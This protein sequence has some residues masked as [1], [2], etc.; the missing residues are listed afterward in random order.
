M[1]DPNRRLTAQ[2]LASALGKD[3]TTIRRHAKAGKIKG[4]QDKSRR[5]SFRLGDFPQLLDR[6][7]RAPARKK[8]TD[9]IFVL[10]RSGSMGFLYKKVLQGLNEQIATIRKSADKDNVYRISVINFNGSIYHTVTARDVCQIT[11]ASSLYLYPSGSTRSYDAIISAIWLAARLDT[12]D[13]QHA[14]LISVVTDGEEG[15]SFNSFWTVA[16][17]VAEAV[18]IGRYTFAFAGPYGSKRTAAMIGF[19]PGNMMQ[20]EQSR[21]SISLLNKALND[22]LSN[23]TAIRAAGLTMSNSFYARS[24]EDSPVDT[25]MTKESTK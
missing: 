8:L 2:Q 1:R 21:G 24:A 20:W 19:T 9:V 6:S 7:T 13:P 4:T 12:K 15:T 10:D 5:W 16:A 17:R 22:S 25:T 11:D 14:F 23:Y 18:K 3:V